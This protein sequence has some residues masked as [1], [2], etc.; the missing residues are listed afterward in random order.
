M[1]R[2]R[3]VVPQVYRLPVW[4]TSVFLVVEEE[5]VT[6]ID[7][8]WR[9][10]GHRILQC[11]RSLHRFPE[12]IAYIVSTHYHADHIGGVAHLKERCPGRVAVHRAEVPFVQG[13]KPLPNPYPNQLLALAMAPL[14]RLARPPA[15][16]VDLVLHDGDRLEPLGGMEVVDSPGHT[17]GSISL[18]FPKIGLLI[19]GDAL[20]YRA[21]RL[22][23]PCRVSTVDM[24]QAKESIRRLARLD[25]EVL[26]F[27]HFPP[28][29][30]GGSRALRRFAE[31]LD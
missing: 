9:I 27:S 7:A 24:A 2:A 3:E 31:T 8:G 4:G 16:A 21:G 13:Q 28:L 19:A 30:R 6:I 12:E 18:H 29:L 5:R 22:Q 1:P 17:P 25:F 23:L 20:Q 14:V 11:L 15:F 10:S 26:C